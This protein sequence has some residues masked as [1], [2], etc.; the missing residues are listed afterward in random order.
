VKT[1]RVLIVDDVPQVRRELRTL[2]PLLDDIDIV[3]EAENG[4][5]AIEL[6]AARQPDVILMDVE[7]PIVDGITA[8]QSIKQASPATRIIILSI[9]N[10]AATRAQARLAGAD[11]FVDKGAPLAALLQA[12]QSI[13][14]AT[15]LRRAGQVSAFCDEAISFREGKAG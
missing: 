13:V 8:T 6:A 7:M 3:G 9:H 2:L 12:I 15:P 1:P 10:D 11:D 14:I 5:S 4:Q